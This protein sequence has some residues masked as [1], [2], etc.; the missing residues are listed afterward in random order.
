MCDKFI[1]FSGHGFISLENIFYE[2]AVT[3]IQQE[4]YSFR[5]IN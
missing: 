2:L 4:L 1:D 3:K 5:D